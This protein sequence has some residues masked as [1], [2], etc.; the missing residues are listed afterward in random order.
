MKSNKTKEGQ[1][2]TLREKH[3]GIIGVAIYGIV[4]LLLTDNWGSYIGI[5]LAL[6]GSIGTYR[7]EKKDELVKQNLDK[8]NS[9]VMWVLLVALIVLAGYNKWQD[10][11]YTVYLCIA[12]AAL[13]LRSTFFLWFDRTPKS[14]A[15]N[16]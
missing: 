10:L 1:I 9:I 16:E 5:M 6:G 2:K 14:D 7:Y 3:I 12:C 11:P 15:E 8:S 4:L 13:A